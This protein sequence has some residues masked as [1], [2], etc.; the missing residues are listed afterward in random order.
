MS[1]RNRAARWAACSRMA[2]CGA[3]CAAL[4]LPVCANGSRRARS[5]IGIHSMLYLDHAFSAKNAMFKE[6]ARVG[7]SEI[8]LDIALAS[9]FGTPDG[10]PDWSGV[11]QYMRLARRYHL[12]VLANLFAT[13][14]YLAACPSGT[15]FGDYR[16][17]ASDPVRWAREAAAVAGHTRGVIDEFEIVN[18]PDGS[19]AFLGSAEQYAAMLAAASEAIHAANPAA[20]VATGG[21]MD[22]GDGGR[23]WMDAVLASLGPHATQAFDI[24]NIHVRGPAAETGRV[25]AR[26]RHYF[27][28]A[29]FEG[30]VWVTEAGYPADASQQ[31]DPA[32]RGGPEAQARYLKAAIPAMISAGAAKVFIT[33]RDALGGGFASEGILNTSDP[34]PADPPYSRRPSF[35]AVRASA[36]RLGR[37]SRA[38]VL[39]SFRSQSPARL[40][41]WVRR[42]KIRPE[43]RE[44]CPRADSPGRRVSAGS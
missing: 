44:S 23:Q 19:W 4:A 14:W 28:R 5:P 18:E 37:L 26:W 29:G 31:T 32:Y 9:V 38:C 21:L 13:P 15:P 17:A 2:S 30:P 22:V 41:Q 1:V 27:A 8:R 42:T 43:R 33:E 39:L 34:L 36:S 40:G 12:K 7:A 25:V 6:A 24:A 20:R 3:L 11:D 16:C 10:A 35:Y